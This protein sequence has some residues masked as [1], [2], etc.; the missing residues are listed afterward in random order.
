MNNSISDSDFDHLLNDTLPAFDDDLAPE[1][2]PP[3]A[4]PLPQQD[5]KFF[6]KIPV[7][8]TLEVASTESSLRELM[9]V[10]ASSVIALDKLAGA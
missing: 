7:T 2:S 10:N 4:A 1:A 8:V 3:E 6:G 5:L 9:D